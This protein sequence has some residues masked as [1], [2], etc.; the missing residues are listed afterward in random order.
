[1]METREYLLD[2]FIESLEIRNLSAHTITAYRKDI[3]LFFAF[4]ADRDLAIE[5]IES[6][7]I[8]SFIGLRVDTDQKKVTT[9]KREI[10]S[11][12]QFMQWAT[13]NNFLESDNSQDVKVK[14]RSQYLPHVIDIETINRLLDQPAPPEP[15]QAQLWVRDKAIM[16]LFYSTGMRLKELHTLNVGNLDS[17]AL[18]VRVT[19]KGNKDRVIPFGKKARDA[20]EA[21]YFVYRQWT[22]S[23]PKHNSPLFIS[24][25]G[26]RLAYSQIAQRIGVQAKRAGFD[27]S[28]HPHL[29]RHSFATHMLSGTG[30]IRAV[31]EMLG[32]VS[33]STTQ[34]Y[35]HLDFD[36]LA[37][38]YDRS[39][40]RASKK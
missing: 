33:L 2:K 23:E 25:R 36:S 27:V 22:N 32:H 14:N 19:G 15:Q 31:Q 26:K 30:D 28:V 21:W 35:T 20:I 37:S 24:L 16:E 10:A 8:R 12:R 29:F 17:R 39:H 38:A 34:I 1:M 7:D 5:D 6:S 9:V 11:I 4:C 13:H 3:E 18:L 40:P